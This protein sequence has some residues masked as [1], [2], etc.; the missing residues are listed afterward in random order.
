MREETALRS[1]LVEICR[2]LER[3]GLIAS[4]DGNVSC[5]VGAD[6]L[7]ITPSGKPKTDLEPR[8]LI[9][10]NALGER[11]SGHG[12]PSS[13]IHM[14]LAVYAQRSDV[15]AIVHAH[16]PLLTAM[17]LAGRPFAADVLPEVWLTVGRVPTAP[18]ATPSTSEVP[19]SIAPFI[20]DHQAI[21]LE[22]H[23]SLSFG[24]TLGEAYRRL[25]ILEHAAHTLFY[26]LLIGGCPPP[27]M[28]DKDREKLDQVR[29]KLFA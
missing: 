19:D 12:R 17:T 18:Y 21:L 22:R 3:K 27:A 5:R 1:E 15:S 29:K 25:E 28:P 2:K 16:P 24:R 23:G 20:A 26:A 14:H 7:L 9:G 10:V 6:R 4:A 13:E 8:D 11:V